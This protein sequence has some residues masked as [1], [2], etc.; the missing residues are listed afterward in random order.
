MTF[1]TDQWMD[2]GQK[3]RLKST[4]DCADACVAYVH[5][6]KLHVSQLC[7]LHTNQNTMITA[8]KVN[9][10]T[11]RIFFLLYLSCTHIIIII[12]MSV[13]LERFSM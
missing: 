11:V 13:F 6:S 3:A 2:N 8:E 7:T 4:N 5:G 1:K 12:I 9:N 10:N